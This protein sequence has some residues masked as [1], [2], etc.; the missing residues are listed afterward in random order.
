[1]S[2]PAMDTSLPRREKTETPTRAARPNLDDWRGD[3]RKQPPAWR[4]RPRS[5]RVRELWRASRPLL[6]HIGEGRSWD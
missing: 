1:M 6:A 2:L 4:R 3:I 5:E